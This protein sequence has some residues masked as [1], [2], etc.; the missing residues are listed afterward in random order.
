MPR[1]RLFY[2]LVWATRGREPLISPAREAG[3]HRVLRETARHHGVIVHAVGGV[4]DHV[5]LAV[6]IPPSLAVATAIQRIKGG[7]ARVLNAEFG[8]GFGWQVD[9]GVDTFSERQLTRV[10][11]YIE[12]QHRHHAEQTL[13]PAIEEIPEPAAHPTHEG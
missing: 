4:A 3:V 2:H 9:Y 13:W 10:V 11:D 8:D 5:H 6:S 12:Q 7:S 1:W